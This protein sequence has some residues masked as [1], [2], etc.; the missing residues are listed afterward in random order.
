[1]KAGDVAHFFQT[2]AT[3]G[4]S[5]SGEDERELNEHVREAAKTR[6][7]VKKVSKNYQRSGV[8]W[9]S[10]SLRK[11]C[12][13]MICGDASLT[14]GVLWLDVGSERVGSLADHTPC[15]AQRYS[16]SM[17]GWK[18]CE[19]RDHERRANPVGEVRSGSVDR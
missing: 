1:M 16:A 13:K 19:R 2:R 12:K 6:V 18:A 3:K 17:D 14:T 10:S 7:E 8:K 5:L 15:A 9:R 4:L 11:S